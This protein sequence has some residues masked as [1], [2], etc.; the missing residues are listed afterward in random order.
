MFLHDFH[1]I[2]KNKFDLQKSKSLEK[3]A[4]QNWCDIIRGKK[5]K[6]IPDPWR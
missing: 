1:I 4:M 6:L 3:M 2:V 5:K